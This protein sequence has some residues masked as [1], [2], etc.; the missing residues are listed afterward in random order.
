MRDKY[1]KLDLG[2]VPTVKLVENDIRQLILNLVRNGLDASIEGNGVTIQTSAVKGKVVL[3]V[4]DNGK[5]IDKEY[6]PKLG[7]PFVTTKEKGTGLGLFICY[8]IAEKHNAAIEVKTSSEG[9]T[10]SVLF[11]A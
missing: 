6:L 7:T 4:Q 11:N 3:T 10:F 8:G 5:G 1:V 2:E 9:T